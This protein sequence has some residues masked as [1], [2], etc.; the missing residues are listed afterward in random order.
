MLKLV[1]L[2]LGGRAADGRQYISWLHYV[3]FVRA[4]YWLIDHDEMEGPVNLAAPNALPNAEFMRILR[5][6]G[7]IRLGLGAT[8]W[9]LEAAAFLMRT[10]TELILKSRWVISSRLLQ[11][12]FTFKF[13]NWPEA[14]DDLCRAW[15]SNKT[16][17]L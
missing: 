17:Q 16:T 12:G 7:G 9:M 3:D 1:R 14:A 8:K 4:V 10:E 6:A 15:K 11:S 2:G 5:K 13:T